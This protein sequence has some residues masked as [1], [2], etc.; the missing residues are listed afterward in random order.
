VCEL[1]L[2]INRL[3]LILYLESFIVAHIQVSQVAGRC[4]MDG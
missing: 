4:I 3:G 2:L 1:A